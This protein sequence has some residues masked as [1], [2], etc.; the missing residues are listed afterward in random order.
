MDMDPIDLTAA[1]AGRA[2]A[3][4]RLS[5]EA[6]ARACL[7]RI[8]LREPEVAAWSYLDPEP[9][10]AQA[11][12]LDAAGPTG[13]LHGLPIGIKDVILT[14]DMP[15]QYNSPI[16]EGFAPAVDAACV[17]TLR[18]A[19]ALIFGK[20]QTVEFASTGRPAQ[21]RNPR[22]LAHTPGGSSSGSA[23]AVA[24]RHVPLALGTQ[25]GGSMIRPASFCGVWA[26][27]PTWNIVSTEGA[28]RFST[29]LD[30]LGWFG[31]AAEDLALLYDVL[32][33]EPAPTAAAFEL[34]GA[35]IAFC[36]TP[37]W[38]SAEA[39][40]RDAMAAAEQRLRAAGARV[41]RLELPAP[42][43]RLN[44][45]QDIV[46]RGE[47]RSAFL[48]DY[49][50]DAARLHPSIRGHVENANG[51]SRAMLCEAYDVAAECRAAFDAMAG[52]FDAVI[53]PS[54]VGTA[55][56]GL[57]QTGALTFN[58]MWTLLHT[59]CVN[60]PA[61]ACADG[62]PVGLTV[63]GPRFADRKVMAVAAAAF[64]YP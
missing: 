2:M 3:Q 29:T 4:G 1:E 38:D 13:P 60:V 63:T 16:Y 33:P 54:T 17:Q 7:A 19:G 64:S 14:R 26:L 32:D 46:M 36:R 40:T 53:T 5:V 31:R 44:A 20:T 27:K 47:G 57:A 39:A 56:E 50:T 52:A 8:A 45:L 9:I 25:T 48:S 37:V 18:A 12:A 11:R 24:D 30:T 6:Y 59:P 51:Y 28:K 10:I 23:A 41:E 62:M 61:F 58:A 21:T 49:R 15:T 34:S 42:F 35:R 55:P 43:D 22:N